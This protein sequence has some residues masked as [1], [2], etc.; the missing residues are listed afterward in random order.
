V[1]LAL[2]PPG[3]QPVTVM[4]AN[5]SDGQHEGQG[6]TVTLTETGGQP[7]GRTV[8]SVAVSVADPEIG[9]A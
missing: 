1:K 7:A 9:A 8:C 2:A 6:S 4:G 3:A 5:V